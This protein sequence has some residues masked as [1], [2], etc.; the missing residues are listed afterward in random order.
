[1]KKLLIIT[2]LFWVCV[3]VLPSF[4]QPGNTNPANRSSYHLIDA[5][6]AKLM[7]EN[8]RNFYVNTFMKKMPTAVDQA[9]GTRNNDD[10]RTIW[11]SS[12]KIRDFMNDVEA[13]ALGSAGHD[14]LSGLRFYYIRY[15]ENKIANNVNPWTKYAY[16]NKNG[17]PTNYQNKHSLMIVPTYFD[18]ESQTHVDF[19]PRKYDSN[20]KPVAISKVL[21]DLIAGESNPNIEKQSFRDNPEGSNSP[22]TALKALMIAPDNSNTINAGTIVP[23]PYNTNTGNPFTR[24]ANVPCTGADFMNFIDGYDNCGQQPLKKITE[25]NTKTNTNTNTN[26]IKTN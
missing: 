11:F 6:L 20:N 8:Y 16:F 7:S 15:P 23:P 13:T 12:E 2:N 5:S 21:Q 17:L 22:R 4:V 3:I 24:S 10:A 26:V 19:D 25:S 9:N 1:M 18:K 14:S